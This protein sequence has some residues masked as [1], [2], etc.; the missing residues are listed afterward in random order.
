MLKITTT[1]LYS[2]EAAIQTG[3]IT[4]IF[5]PNG[6]GKTSLLRYLATAI[7]D[8]PVPVDGIR[9]TDGALFL[10]PDAPAGSITVEYPDGK[11]VVQFPEIIKSVDGKPFKISE[12]AAGT[13]LFID[14]NQKQRAELIGAIL[15]T[16]PTQDE[17]DAALEKLNLSDDVL[18]RLWATIQAQ[19]W[20]AAHT[21]AKEKGI[22]LK[23]SWESETGERYGSEKAVGWLPSDW[24][25]EL[26]KKSEEQ[27]RAEI[28]HEQEWLE[29]AISNEAVSASEIERLNKIA[30]DADPVKKLISDS[31]GALAALRKNESD[32]S[33][34]LAAVPDFNQ[35][36]TQKCPKCNTDL[37]IDRGR[38]AAAHII[39]AAEIAARKKSFDAASESLRAVRAEIK[40][41]EA[42][43][44]SG[45][46]QMKT[47][48]EAIERLNI[49]QNKKP[50]DQTHT[51]GVA[52]CRA[53]VAGAEYRLELFRKRAKSS[54]V[55][56]Q[57]AQNKIIVDVLSPDGLRM[58]KLRSAIARVNTTLSE[59]SKIAGWLPV[60]I[61]PTMAVTYGDDMFVLKSASEQFRCAVTIQ[62]MLAMFDSSGIILIDGADILD[63]DGRN[64]LFK[65]LLSCDR[66]A[67]VACTILGG[68]ENS[69]AISKIGGIGYWIEHGTA[70]ALK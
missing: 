36:A 10:S 23:G 63:K 32:I 52:D 46:A 47:I 26:D 43:A 51:R 27:L 35:P 25:P 64:G 18:D 57:I 11:T 66:E 38:I 70:E 1:G 59:L 44:Q 19:G 67:I 45:T 48:N 13:K 40:R 68:R 50:A 54:A 65:M 16:L 49:I 17:L 61:T 39:P 42:A 4:G 69:P 20:D 2:S 29:A 15:Q 12:Y 60:Q 41:N 56:S 55:A 37:M 3:K 30:A 62:V 5:G 8:R 22:K 34:A 7:T 28:A 14:M 6:S 33:A 24:V 21:G 31:I 53:R 58:E 9:K